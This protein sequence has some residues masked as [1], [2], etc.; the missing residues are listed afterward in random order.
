VWYDVDSLIEERR[1]TAANTL[2]RH[3]RVCNPYPRQNENSVSGN[4]KDF[5]FF[6]GLNQQDFPHNARLCMR[7][8]PVQER[9]QSRVLAPGVKVLRPVRVAVIL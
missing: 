9:R 7:T 3:N 2:L 8:G 6:L 1:A 5:F 4:K